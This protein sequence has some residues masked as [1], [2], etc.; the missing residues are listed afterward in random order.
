MTEKGQASDGE[1]G[2]G[3]E[4]IGSDGDLEKQ[5]AEQEPAPGEAVG[6]EEA[7]IGG[8][9]QKAEGQRYDHR[10]IDLPDHLGDGPEK[11]QR[12]GREREGF[13]SSAA[14]GADEGIDGEP[15]AE[16]D[17]LANGI[18]PIRGIDD[19]RLGEQ[20]PPGGQRV[21][22]VK[23]PEGFLGRIVEIAAEEEDPVEV[24]TNGA[25][26]EAHAAAQKVEKAEN[27]QPSGPEQE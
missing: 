15:A 26:A 25:D 12:P 8:D 7:D 6:I 4:G 18:D 19:E 23:G 21:A 17:E 13:C 5:Q 24:L 11:S 14:E 22:R 27:G 20:V 16:V 1:A 10:P 2:G 9:G 3:L